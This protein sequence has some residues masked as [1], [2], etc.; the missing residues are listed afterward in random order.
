MR[1]IL[2]PAAFAIFNFLGVWS[3]RTTDYV[4]PLADIYEAF[5]FIA[6]L[7][8]LLAYTIPSSDKLSDQ[9]AFFIQHQLFSYRDFRRTYCYMVQFLPVTICCIVI[10]E[11]TMAN[12]CW[13]GRGWRHAHLIIGIVGAVS[14]VL[15]MLGLFG[16]YRKLGGDIK[17]VQ[18]RILGQLFIFKVIV[19]I[20]LVQGLLLSVLKATNTLTPTRTMSYNDLNLGLGPFLT[21]CEALIISCGMCYFYNPKM[22]RSNAGHVRASNESL[23]KDNLGL[24]DGTKTNVSS[25]K[26]GPLKALWDVVNV[27]DVFRG[28]GNALWLL[29][30]KSVSA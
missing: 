23:S 4:T 17:K 7:F 19:F 16:I 30:H 2:T 3:Y 21:C 22:H 11:I 1:I 10:N 27:S 24:E 8:M 14:T 6:I 12:T 26:L 9:I 20:H 13:G 29:T 5:V 25:P 15:A 18:P 28:M